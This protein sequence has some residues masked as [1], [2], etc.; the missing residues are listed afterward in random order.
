MKDHLQEE[1]QRNDFKEW[2]HIDIYGS[3]HGI[4]EYTI[5]Q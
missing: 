5:Q 2:D 1:E 3:K 4:E